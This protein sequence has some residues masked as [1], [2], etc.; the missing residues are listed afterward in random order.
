[1]TGRRPRRIVVAPG[2]GGVVLARHPLPGADADADALVLAPDFVGV[3]GTDLD[4]ARAGSASGRM[5][6]RTMRGARA[7]SEPAA[8]AR[9]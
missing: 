2:G 9:G 6:C 7:P 3:C 4:A 8:R 1:M 5:I